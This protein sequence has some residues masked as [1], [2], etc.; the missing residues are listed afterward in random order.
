MSK[1]LFSGRLTLPKKYSVTSPNCFHPPI[2]KNGMPGLLILPHLDHW[3][4]LLFLIPI[5][6]TQHSGIGH[7]LEDAAMSPDLQFHFSPLNNL[8]PP[9]RPTPEH[10]WPKPHRPKGGHYSQTSTSTNLMPSTTYHRLHIQPGRTIVLPAL[11]SI[12][13]T[14][15]SPQ[16]TRPAAIDVIWGKRLLECDCW[17]FHPSAVAFDTLWLVHF[18]LFANEFFYQFC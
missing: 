11:S 12:I 8:D 10:Q 5:Q 2:T 7:T 15:P 4:W 16:P 1:S 6:I 18:I 14:T 9:T 3:F 17:H 13:H